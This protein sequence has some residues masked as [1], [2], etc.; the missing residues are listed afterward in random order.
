L[1]IA[2]C[3]SESVYSDALT[4]GKKYTVLAVSDD[5]RQIKIKSNNGRQRWFPSI[6]FDLTGNEV[7][8]ITDIVI[9]DDLNDPSTASVEVTVKLSNG[10]D[11]W[12]FF[13]TPDMLARSS[14]IQLDEGV[15]NMYG[16]RHLIVVSTVTGGMITQSLEAID[17]QGELMNC[18]LPVNGT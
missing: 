16:V 3:I 18:T 4:R 11:R 10:E 9:D 15:I 17:R 5:G 8:F 14:Q 6:S 7:P 1:D 12:C 2:T 13:A